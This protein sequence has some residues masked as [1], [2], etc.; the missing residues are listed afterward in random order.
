MIR[1]ILTGKGILEGGAMLALSRRKSGIARDPDLDVT[2]IAPVH[3]PVR[4]RVTHAA[5]RLGGK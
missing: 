1:T 4:R 3:P 2:R 5:A